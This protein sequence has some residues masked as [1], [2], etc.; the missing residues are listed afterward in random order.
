MYTNRRI[1]K[2]MC[3]SMVDKNSPLE[4]LD[5]EKG[6]EEYSLLHEVIKD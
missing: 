1:A 6:H 3:A 2:E 5:G 4:E